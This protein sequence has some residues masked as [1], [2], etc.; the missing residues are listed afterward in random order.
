MIF[1]EATVDDIPQLQIVRNAVRE[2]VLSDPG[3]ITYDDY[4]HYLAVRGKGWVCEFGSLI[5]G[6]SIVDVVG[7][8]IWALFVLPG[9]EKKGI[10]RQLHQLMMNWYFNET[11]ETVWLST[12]PGSRAEAFYRT[13]GW[14]ETGIYGKGETRFEMTFDEWMKVKQV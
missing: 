12:A 9:F 1:R 2:N 8:N 6:F 7:R 14:K 13:A 11:R 4:H 10:G 3:L 5:V